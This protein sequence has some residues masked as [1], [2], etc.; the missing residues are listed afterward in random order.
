MEQCV[1]G[2]AGNTTN[3]ETEPFVDAHDM[4]LIYSL[5]SLLLPS[6]SPLHPLSPTPSLLLPPLSP[7]HPL[8]PTPSLLLPPL[9][10]LHPLSPTPSLHLSSFLTR[11][12][13]SPPPGH[14]WFQ[15]ND[16]HV[17]PIL[18]KDLEKMYQGKQSAYMLFYRRKTLQRP[19]EGNTLQRPLEGNTLEASRR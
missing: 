5:F 19:P 8:S 2:S 15:F 17:S 12:K 11:P 18:A 16:T 3:S 6:L 10:L 1:P 14:C 7:L 9:S 13:P 4:L